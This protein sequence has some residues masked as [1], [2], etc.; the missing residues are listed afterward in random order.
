MVDNLSSDVSQPTNT[1]F[2][3]ERA[4]LQETTFPT[5]QMNLPSGIEAE[6]PEMHWHAKQQLS[7]PTQVSQVQWS[8]SQAAGTTIV[9]F[10]F[11]EVLASVDSVIRRTLQMYAFY[12]MSPVFRFQLNSTQ[13]HQGQLII[14][15]DPFRQ[16]LNS[17]VNVTTPLSTN[18]L[19]NRYYATG[20][21]SVKIMASESD[22]VELHIPYIHPRNFLTSNTND[23]DSIDT[24]LP[25]V[26]NLMGEI[27]VTVLNQLAAADGASTALTLTTWVYAADASVHVPIY[28]HSLDVQPTSAISSLVSH[29]SNLIGNIATGNIGKGLRSGQGLIDDLGKLFGFDY[30]NRPLAPEN[31]IKPVETLAN[32]RGATRSERLALDPV[33]G[34]SPDKEEIMTSLDEMDLNKVIKLPMLISTFEFPSTAAAK[35][36]LLRIPVRPMI[37]ANNSAD[38]NI[39][40]S[41][42]G[43]VSQFFA[44]W[45]G[46]IQYEFEF[47]ATRFHSGKLL[48]AFVPNSIIPLGTTITYDLLANSNPSAIL[49][50]Q[51]TSKISFT[52]PF[53]SAT[54]LKT[55]YVNSSDLSQVGNIYVFVQNQ[56]VHASNVAPRIDVNVYVR[57]GPDF[58]FMVPRLPNFSH[59]IQP[60]TVEATSDISFQ[61][62][63]TGQEN[64]ST[65]LTLGQPIIH[66][67]P[68][69]GET[70]S[71]IDLIRRF[72]PMTSPRT[73]VANTDAIGVH[74]TYFSTSLIDGGA[75]EQKFLFDQDSFTTYL[76]RISQ[77][78]S[79]WVGSLRYKIMTS[80][81]RSSNTKLSIVHLPDSQFDSADDLLGLNEEQLAGYAASTTDLSQ[82]TS[83]EIEVPYYSPFNFLLIHPTTNVSGNDGNPTLNLNYLNRAAYPILNGYLKLFTTGTD[84]VS[85]R[86]YMSVGEDFKM[87]YLRA[88]PPEYESQLSYPDT[89]FG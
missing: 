59:T 46:S 41:F 24:L 16:S 85:Y 29:G 82:N 3:E 34:H 58:S 61:T 53:Q 1:A 55:T 25:S 51:Q 79:C 8:I 54:P 32:A 64:S 69:F 35:S 77:I 44:Y 45:Q 31:T 49:D 26:Y 22:P 17:T 63:R 74:P 5:A 57:A 72:T 11:P 38:S 18:P 43:F 89:F 65:V 7:K 80:A 13:F 88:P 62:S 27:R 28:N 50:I 19:F 39:Q 2:L 37:G 4:L 56:L 68:R 30:P 12:K 10:T 84:A 33:S 76:S 15:F 60:A 9:D 6:F 47:V 23:P 67:K 71:L 42:L 66:P 81:P 87:F 86:S 20:L 52:V 70:F 14:S 40:P 48:V 21:P 78:Y 83:L 73:I 36:P 75:S